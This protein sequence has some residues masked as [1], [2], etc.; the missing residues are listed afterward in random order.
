MKHLMH[1]MLCNGVSPQHVVRVRNETQHST[2]SILSSKSRRWTRQLSSSRRI[3]QWFSIWSTAFIAFEGRV[4]VESSCTSKHTETEATTL[5]A[6]TVPGNHTRI[7]S[8]GQLDFTTIQYRISAPSDL[9]ISVQFFSWKL[10]VIHSILQ[11][12]LSTL[13]SCCMNILLDKYSTY[14]WLVQAIMNPISSNPYTKD[15]LIGLLVP[16]LYEI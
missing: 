3:L 1:H 10:F 7:I 11:I 4:A 2:Q 12:I 8:T 13:M 6:A 15:F 9:K 14:K 16:T 5:T